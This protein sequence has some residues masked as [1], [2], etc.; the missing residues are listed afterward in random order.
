MD[1]FLHAK[2]SYLTFLTAQNQYAPNTI[3]SYGACICEFFETVST[4]HPEFVELQSI[5][6]DVVEEWFIS[7]RNWGV[8]TT[9]LHV[10][11]IRGFL[12]YL[13]DKRIYPENPCV[14][15]RPIK[16]RKRVDESLDDT[17]EDKV[18]TS[19][20]LLQL[21]EYKP[22]A[23][24]T[25]IRDRAV[26]ALM[27]GS[28][29]RASEVGWLDVGAFRRRKDG[30]IYA[31]RKG[32]N[33]RK[34]FVADFAIP[35][36]EEYLAT[37]KDDLQDDSP[38]FVATTGRR[39]T[40][41]HVDDLLRVRQRALG[42]R[43]GTHNMRYTVLNSVE[44]MSDPAVARDIAGHRNMAITNHYMVTSTE[45]RARAVEALP[46]NAKLKK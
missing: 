4:H 38:L 23:S 34:V 8:E 24:K 1:E 35:Y 30:Y 42:L 17:R 36:V 3:A 43:T 13:T 25:F 28:G 20:Q 6:P 14:I 40:R 41:D 29:M 2:D 9:R 31:L 5:T 15:L 22:R 16:K 46:W 21:L 44:R 37:R 12:Q 18:Y 11:A 26:I 39:I 33:I 32:Q 27:A 7:H 19:E 10:A 45:E